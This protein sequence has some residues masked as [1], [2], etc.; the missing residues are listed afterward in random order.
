[1]KFI[2]DVLLEN[3]GIKLTAIFM[4]FFLWL[5]VRGDRNVERIMTIAL[6]IRVPRNM[7]ITN[8]RPSFVEIT[9][10]GTPMSLGWGLSG[11]PAY[12]IDLQSAGEGRHEIPL[13][14]GN[15]RIPAASGLEVVRVNPPRITLV[16]EQ[17]ISKNVAVSLPPLRGEPAEGFDVYRVSYWPTL[18]QITG[19]RSR[20]ETVSQLNT[21]PVSVS[22][23]SQSLRA[24][25]GLVVEDHLVR[26]NP[27]GPVEVNVQV[28][29]HRE[30]RTIAGIQVLSEDE[31]LDVNPPRISVQ[32]LVPVTFKSKLGPENF[33][34]SILPESLD[35]STKEAKVKPEVRLVD[36]PDPDI[37]IEKIR[38]PEVV[39]R[40]TG[41]K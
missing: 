35:P 30:T 21:A 16:L 20:V 3:W 27:A 18:V 9:V 31:S 10:R 40:R 4:A 15:V 14:P 24:F 13:S 1:M 12:T 41:K 6:E 8:E 37:V 33:S 38:P 17:T 34:A 32:V 39:V 26:V 5:F 36:S 19:P 28:G 23:L 11:P 25:A 29:V 22:G 2:K 7:E